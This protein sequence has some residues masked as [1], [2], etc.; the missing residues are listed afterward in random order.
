MHEQDCGNGLHCGHCR[1]A[2]RKSVELKC[3]HAYVEFTYLGH[4]GGRGH[5]IYLGKAEGGVWDEYNQKVGGGRLAT[6]SP[7]LDFHLPKHLKR[8]KVK[9]WPGSL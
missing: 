8:N 7:K 5:V 1:G 2:Y 6:G 3:H 9:T 4:E